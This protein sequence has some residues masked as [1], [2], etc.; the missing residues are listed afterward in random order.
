MKCASPLRGLLATPGGVHIKH[1]LGEGGGFLP[2]ETRRVAQNQDALV[3]RSTMVGLF[4]CGAQGSNGI[5]P[6]WGLPRPCWGWLPLGQR[7]RAF[8]NGGHPFRRLV[9]ISGKP[10]ST[11]GERKGNKQRWL[12]RIMLNLGDCLLKQ[13]TRY[14]MMFCRSLWGARGLGGVLTW[15]PF[16]TFIQPFRKASNR[17]Q[18]KTVSNMIRQWRGAPFFETGGLCVCVCV[19]V[20]KASSRFSHSRPIQTCPS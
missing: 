20:L 5:S 8:E 19:C 14:V 17:D 1:G 2:S 18:R 15:V 7:L 16:V 6:K 12:K 4:A 9:G 11:A 3:D 13:T 10:K